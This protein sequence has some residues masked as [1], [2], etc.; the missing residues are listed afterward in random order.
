MDFSK[1]NIVDGIM[2]IT[3]EDGSVTCIPE[4]NCTSE[5]CEMF[6]AFREAFPEGKP[7]PVIEPQPYVKSD[8]ERISDL[9]LLILQLGGV[10]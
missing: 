10:I 7:K 2:I 6:R 1:C 8:S 3:N 9:E 4:E 5:E